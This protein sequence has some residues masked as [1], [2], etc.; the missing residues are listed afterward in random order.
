MTSTPV[1]SLP[2]FGLPFEIETDACDSGVGAV[3]SQNGHPVAFYSKALGVNNRKLSIYEKEFIAILMAVD[4]WRCYLQRGPFV[5]KTDHKSLCHLQDQTLSTDWQKKAM[6]KLAG[7]QFKLQYKKGTENRVADALSRVGHAF[8]CAAISGVTPI[9][10]QEVLNSYTNDSVSQRLLTELAVVSPNASGYSL[11]HGLIYRNTQILVGANT[12]L[13]TK[14]IAAFH[15]SAVGGHSGVQATYQRVKKLFY[16]TGMKTDVESFIKQCQVCQQAKHEH[17]KYPGL[18]QPLPVPQSSWVDVSMDFIEGLPKS[19]SFSV[20]LVIVDRLTKYAHFLPL[21]HPFTAKGV[22]Q[23]FFD[24]VVKLH[25]VPQT[26]VSDRDRV[27]TAAFWQELFT[28]L[29]TKLHMSSAYHPQT[30]GQ[31]E[32]VNQ[33]LEMF[34]RCAVSDS[35]KLWHKW[36]SSAELWYNST[37]H[38]AIQC[39]P[40]KALYGVDPSLGIAPRIPGENDTEASSFLQDRQLLF[41]R[42]KDHLNRAQTKMKHYADKNRSPR[43]FQVGD[44]VFL[45][46]QPY[47]Q[48]SVA[49]RPFPKLAFKYFGP[50]KILERIGQAA[51]KLELPAHAQVHPVFHVS[52]L[53]PS[54]PDFTPVFDDVSVIPNLDTMDVFPE[55]I[56]DRR[57][58]KKGSSA[59]TQVKIK[60]S[61]LPLQMATW[62][63]Y[64][65]LKEKF[66]TAPAWGPAGTQGGG[67]VTVDGKTQD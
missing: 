31:T 46:L 56:L 35:P 50:Y 7:L 67:I 40:F 57:L 39:T 8:E 6:A 22:A 19:D 55:L 62:E 10:L 3:L 53:K 52:Q 2:N 59:V 12:A 18:L 44:S 37:Y 48:S 1:L 45:K 54:V 65:V 33:C 23:L 66:P 16:W 41:S 32:R 38:A 42:L 29:D 51:Y 11:K 25:G 43:Q 21:K 13:R 30:D 58:V 20:I 36:L 28:L 34:L 26:V 61:G 27:F 17:C 47:A 15:S 5:I 24:N 49:N 60:W 14:V 64:Y 9:W 63:D 4:K